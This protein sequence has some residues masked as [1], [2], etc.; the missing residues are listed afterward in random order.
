MLNS[1]RGRSG[2]I[3]WV[4]KKSMRT[5]FF[6]TSTLRSHPMLPSICSYWNWNEFRNPP[7]VEY[8]TAGELAKLRACTRRVR[9]SWQLLVAADDCSPCDH[10]AGTIFRGTRVEPK[11]LH[12][13]GSRTHL[14]DILFRTCPG[15]SGTVQYANT[16]TAKTN[17]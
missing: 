8:A 10:I 3:L 12:P 15:F 16:A 14:V 17:T 11:H 4:K 13:R 2:R 9:L 1:A 7:A 6:V 5:T